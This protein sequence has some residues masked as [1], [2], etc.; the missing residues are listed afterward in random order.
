[1]A[2]KMTGLSSVRGLVEVN[3]KFQKFQVLQNTLTSLVVLNFLFFKAVCDDFA[4]CLLPMIV[5]NAG[6]AVYSNPI[7]DS[8]EKET[9]T[10][11]LASLC[12]AHNHADW[13]R[14]VISID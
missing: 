6:V 5:T 9:L 4:F 3:F 13:H 11:S 8:L 7:F 14:V 1:M 10:L 12:H 2:L